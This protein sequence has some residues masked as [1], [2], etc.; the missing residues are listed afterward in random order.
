M[1]QVLA[2]IAMIFAAY[3]VVGYNDQQ[4]DN[5]ARTVRVASIK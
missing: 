4:A 1:K 5:H 2:G 3:L